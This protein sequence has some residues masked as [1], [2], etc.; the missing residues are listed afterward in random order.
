MRAPLDKEKKW[1]FI[2]FVKYNAA[3][4]SPLPRSKSGL[5]G[6]SLMKR[7]GLDKQYKKT[8]MKATS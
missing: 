5:G 2:C 7:P 4:Y 6:G 1:F 8:Q 3:L